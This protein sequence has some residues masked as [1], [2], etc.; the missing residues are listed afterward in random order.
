MD[1][2]S[3]EAHEV[4]LRFDGARWQSMHPA[5]MRLD[6]TA[7]H[8]LSNVDFRY[9]LPACLLCD[10]P[11]EAHGAN[12]IFHLT[13]DLSTTASPD[14]RPAVLARPAGFSRSEGPAIIGSHR[15]FEAMPAADLPPGCP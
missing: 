14:H 2:G 15:L 1:G 7:L 9:F 8:W 3:H 5:L 11:G 12:L 13:Q 10:L 4:T 6:G